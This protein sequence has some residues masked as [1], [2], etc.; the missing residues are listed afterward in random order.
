VLE[1]ACHSPKSLLQLHTPAMQS[2]TA[3]SFTG[4]A[5][6]Q[7]QRV[8][9]PRIAAAA[10]PGRVF[11]AQTLYGKVVSVKQ[12]KTAVVEV[13]NLQVHPVYQK[14]V[15]VSSMQAIHMWAPRR[16]APLER[17]RWAPHHL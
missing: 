7:Q 17:R 2:L 13:T 1:F 9:A 10:A 3:S 11:A 12:N 6:Q 15:R 4:A 14:R 16:Q 8:A 5:L